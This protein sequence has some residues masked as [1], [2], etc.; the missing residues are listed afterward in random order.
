MSSSA[1]PQVSPP[2]KA[3]KRHKARIL[4]ALKLCVSIGLIYFLLSNVGWEELLSKAAA[5]DK[6]LIL[7][8]ALI[9]FV[10]F[11]LSTWKWSCALQQHHLSFK[12]LYLQTV[13]C[14]GYFLNNFL[15][16][17][18]GGDAYRVIKTLPTEGRKSRA[19]SATLMDRIAGLS[20]LLL[21][22]YTAAVYL[23]WTQDIELLRLLV[24]IA[25]VGLLIAVPAFFIGLKVGLLKR[26]DALPKIGAKLLPLTEN[27]RLIAKPGANLWRFLAL[28]FA[29]QITAIVLLAV[30][31]KAAGYAV[32][33]AYCAVIIAVGGIVVM[34]PISIAGIGVYEGALVGAAVA[35]GLQAEPTIIASVVL[36][37]LTVPAS[38]ICG[39]IFLSSSLKPGKELESY[40]EG[41]QAIDAEL[42][43][44]K[45]SRLQENPL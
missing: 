42:P 5:V 13:S 43:S 30:L 38:A 10:Q 8:A 44:G 18:I 37:L 3:P 35:L 11:P 34:L 16:T 36:R 45:Q 6:P 23:W 24:P 19:V 32:P 26:I 7:L 9:V 25:T 40:N 12:F 31:F 27:L 41:E 29:F 28:S 33:L 20:A 21:M 15:P 2:A 4:I 14:I 17:G 22:A 39:L 1:S